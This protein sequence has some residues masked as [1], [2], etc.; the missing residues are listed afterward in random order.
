MS[1]GVGLDV[2]ALGAGALNYLG[3]REANRANKAMAREQMA[4]QERMSNTAYQRQVEDMRKAGLNPILALN[5]GG[6][7]TPPGATA[8]MTNEL[9][10]SLSSAVEV[11]RANAEVQ[12]LKAQNKQIESQTDLNRELAKVAKEEQLLKA[13]NAKAVQ[14]TL[15][16]L[17]TEASID[18][19]Y[20]GTAMRYLDRIGKTVQNFNP[21]SGLYNSFFGKK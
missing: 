16:G 12:N 15:P 20:F 11:R 9:Q 2:G 5:Q 7:S 1:F 19:G 21:L 6:A 10:G 18:K 4:F 14:A 3:A 8:T 13:S 17:E